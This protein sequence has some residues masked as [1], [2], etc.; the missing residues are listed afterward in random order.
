MQNASSSEV[1]TAGWHGQSA[2]PQHTVKLQRTHLHG[3]VVGKDIVPWGERGWDAIRK[4]GCI[5][6][7]CECLE[8]PNIG[9][10]PP[11]TSW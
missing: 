8:E 4:E 6:W 5:H 9:E 2:P 10:Y 1:L 3:P 7:C 11:P